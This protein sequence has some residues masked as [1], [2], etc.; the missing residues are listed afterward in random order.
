MDK[1]GLWITGGKGKLADAVVASIESSEMF[2]KTVTRSAIKPRKAELVLVSVDGEEV[3]YIGI[4][5]SGRR[6]STGQI[7]I[8]VSNLKEI[9]VPCEKLKAA[10]PTRLS[11]YFSIP[12][13]GAYRPGPKLWQE[14]LRILRQSEPDLTAVVRDLTRR[15]TAAQVPQGRI[16]GGLEVFERDAVASALQVF[17]GSAFRKKILRKAGAPVRGSVAPFLERLEG[18][19]VR[20]D[21]Q[22][23]HDQSVFPGL[24]VVRRDVVGAAFLTN[25]TEKLTILNCNRQPLEQTLGVDL[26]YYNHGYDSFVL[27]QYKRMTEGAK[28][29]EYRPS[30]DASHEKEVRRMLEIDEFLK[31][32]P[33]STTTATIDYRLS[34]RPFYIKLCEPKAKAALDAGMVSGMYVPL[35]L[36]QKFLASGEALGKKG[37]VVVTWDNCTRRFNNG[38][39]TSLLR[40]GWIGSAR[41][42]SKSLSEIVEKVLAS[43]RMLVFAGTSK[44]RVS[45]DLRRDHL[46]RFAADDD[47]EGAV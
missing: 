30:N 2:S 42:E 25:G 46:G 13:E 37:G 16:G 5:Q 24:N 17:G 39:F 44:G 14:L 19:S 36:W 40:N 4:S 41:G 26:I 18:A 22:I 35:E 9:G 15:V 43:G 28:G 45:E 31:R 6:V 12:E 1:S 33:A 3:D 38:E 20:E 29:A 11:R 34:G 8:V 21:P 10:L 7:T 27:V 32:A 23:I 47:P